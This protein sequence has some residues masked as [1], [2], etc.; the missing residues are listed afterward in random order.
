[1]KKIKR[2]TWAWDIEAEQWDRVTTVCAVSDAGDVEKF[3][4]PGC[5]ERFQDQVA[6]RDRGTFVAH[7]GGI[8]DTLLYSQVRENRGRN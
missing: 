8:Y 1:V 4:G 6:E 3:S 7:A 2:K 5:L